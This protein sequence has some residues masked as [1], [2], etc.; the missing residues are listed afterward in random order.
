MFAP[1]GLNREHVQV[2]RRAAVSANACQDR[3]DR[4]DSFQQAA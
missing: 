3:V 1:A 2:V 4:G